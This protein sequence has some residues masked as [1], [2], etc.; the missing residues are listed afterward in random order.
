MKCDIVIFW[1]L[2]SQ[3][4][5][6]FKQNMKYKYHTLLLLHKYLRIFICHSNYHLFFNLNFQ[7]IYTTCKQLAEKQRDVLVN[8][9]IHPGC[10][11]LEV[12]W[13]IKCTNQSNKNIL[14]RHFIHLKHIIYHLTQIVVNILLFLYWLFYTICFKTLSFHF[15]RVIPRTAF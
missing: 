11:S 1:N 12:S 6:Q 9:I 7:E 3:P 8:A 5:I 14:S 13:L 2:S 15:R 10:S 4:L